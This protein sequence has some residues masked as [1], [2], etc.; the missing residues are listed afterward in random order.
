VFWAD[1]TDAEAASGAEDIFASL[2]G[3]DAKVEAKKVP[4]DGFAS[5]FRVDEKVEAKKIG[6][7]LEALRQGRPIPELERL[8]DVRFYVLGLSPNAARLSVR[9]FIED[10]FTRLTRRLA[11]H[12]DDLAIEPSPFR[13]GPAIW[14]LFYETAVHVPKEGPNGQ[15]IWRRPKDSAP[16]AILTGDTMRAVLT[17]SRYPQTLLSR[18]IQRVRAERGRVN[19][20]RAA[21]CKAI[22]NRNA[23]L[24]RSEG[25][26]HFGSEEDISVAL[27]NSNPNAA[28]RLGRL[29]ALMESAQKLAL[30]NLNAT[31]RDR[32]FGAASTTPARVFPLLV[33]TA[34]YHLSAARKDEKKKRIAFWLERSMGEVWSGLEANLP[35]MLRLEDQGRFQVGYYHQRFAKKDAGGETNVAAEEIDDGDSAEVFEE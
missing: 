7:L 3:V 9:F 14:A 33:R 22:V 16:P 5:L 30:P 19:G 20:A 25:A 21:I 4:E 13:I 23:R 35:R 26:C 31:I 11:T 12:F 27:D 18:I 8:K 1:A 28:Y 34:M 32:F 17:G 29:F 10:D 6:A 15:I 24:S 2:L